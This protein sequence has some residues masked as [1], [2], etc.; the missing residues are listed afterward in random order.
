M[1]VQRGIIH[2]L[3]EQFS[4]RL[5]NPKWPI[6]KKYIH[7]GN[8]KWTQFVLCVCVWTYKCIYVFIWEGL[9]WDM[10]GFGQEKWDGN[11]VNTAFMYEILKKLE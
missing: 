5:Y 1:S 3:Q 7:M 9:K 6:L 8:A 11:D 2:L 10:G 4:D